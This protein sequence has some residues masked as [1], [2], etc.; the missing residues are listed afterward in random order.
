LVRT[1]CPR[2]GIIARALLSVAGLGAIGLTTPSVSA[3]AA[4]P[5]RS[6]GRRSV[7]VS[8]VVLDRQTEE[9]VADASVEMRLVGS[10]TRLA[11]ALTDRAGA[12]SMKPVPAGDYVVRVV[13]LGY[14]EIQ[15]TIALAEGPPAQLTA[16]LTP[17]AVDLPPMV[18]TVDQRTPP[19]MI[20]FERRRG[21]AIGT[22]L[23]R[24]DIE[25][26]HATRVTDLFRSIPGI[27]VVP[28]GLTGDGIL[29]MRGGCRPALV[30]DG[31]PAFGG[32]SLDMVM[33]PQDVEGIEVYGLAGTPIEYSRSQCGTVM[34]WTRAPRRVNGRGHPWKL[35]AVMGGVIAT[36]IVIH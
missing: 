35:L 7:S 11:V 13:R 25:K 18:V 3:Q 28:T 33:T 30:I 22:F 4:G 36:L 15:D 31:T 10:P 26:R 21:Q 23:T 14:K 29:T 1:A 27:R 16:Y 5:E 24:A 20:G 17:E 34:V 12:F 6:N 32:L 8:G 2:R 9:A 19:K